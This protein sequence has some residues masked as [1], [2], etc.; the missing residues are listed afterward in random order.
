MRNRNYFHL[1]VCPTPDCEYNTNRKDN[2]D[3]HIKTC[4]N[5]IQVDHK[6]KRMNEPCIRQWCVDNMH[7]NADYYQTNFA[8]FDIETLGDIRNEQITE[9]THLYN[10]QRVVTISVTKSF[11][12]NESKTKV[13]RRKS[14]SVTDY[15]ELIIDFL[16]YL[17]QIQNELVDLLPRPVLES[18]EKLEKSIAEF[19]RGERNY[20]PAQSTNISR[21]LHY[22]RTMKLLKVYGYNSSGFD[23]PV[24]FQ[25]EFHL[26]V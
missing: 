16:S 9:S 13:F 10:L 19:R 2:L 5:T 6:Q 24:L 15:E 11:G 3:T 21:G 1:F 22:L 23:I 17:E 4:F 12:S 26:K 7:L 14:F 18:I 8:T 25:G 20:S